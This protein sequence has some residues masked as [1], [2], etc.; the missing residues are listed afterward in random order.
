MTKPDTPADGLRGRD[1]R[2]GDL[3]DLR[4]GAY[5]PGNAT[6]KRRPLQVEEQRT[7]RQDAQPGADVRGDTVAAQCE[8][9]LPEG[10]DRPR[11]G[12]LNKS[13][14]RKPSRER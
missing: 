11:R 12:P 14:G 4:D 1:N 9:S 7:A 8:D 13:T 5:E 10:L 2:Q 3:R 6:G